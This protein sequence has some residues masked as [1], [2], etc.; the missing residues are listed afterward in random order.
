M[1]IRFAKREDETGFKPVLVIMQH[2][3]WRIPLIT[4]SAGLLLVAAGIAA[5]SKTLGA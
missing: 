1:I 4:A 3:T 5:L 2:T